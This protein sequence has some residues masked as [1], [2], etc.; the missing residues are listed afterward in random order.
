[1]TGDHDPGCVCLPCFARRTT[2]VTGDVSQVCSLAALIAVLA[3]KADP[4]RALAYVQHLW[5][6]GDRVMWRFTNFG[7][8]MRPVFVPEIFSRALTV[9]PSGALDERL[10]QSVYYGNLPGDG[11]A[12]RDVECGAYERRTTIQPGDIVLDIGAHV[13]FFSQRCLDRGAR[14]VAIEPD[15]RNFACLRDR[16]LDAVLIQGAAWNASGTA[17]LKLNGACTAGHSLYF[18]SKTDVHVVTQLVT[19]DSL[20]LPKCDFIKIDAEGAEVEI[21]QGALETLRTHRPALVIEVDKTGPALLPVLRE[22][23]YSTFY[24]IAKVIDEPEPG[25]RDTGIWY[26]TP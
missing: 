4:M 9:E 24:S 3:Q 7:E 26:V 8:E 18:G 16:V 21:I 10:L 20:Q 5:D 22:A 13:G 19:I 11:L 14:V 25:T 15:V 1:M 2:A 17:H 23:G 6:H 12:R